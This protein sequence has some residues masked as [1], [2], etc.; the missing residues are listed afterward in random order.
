MAWRGLLLLVALAAG[1]AAAEPAPAPAQTVFSTSRRFVVSGLP[2]VDAATLCA[3]AEDVAERIEA[4]THTPLGFGDAE[5]ILIR[6]MDGAE[7]GESRVVRAQGYV[8]GRL[9]QKL[10]VVRPAAADQ[11]DMIESLCGLIVSRQIAQ[12]QSDAERRRALGH[13]PDWLAVGLAQNLYRDLRARNTRLAVDLHREGVAPSVSELIGLA[14]MPPGRWREKY[15][16]GLAVAWLLSQPDLPSHWQALLQRLAGGAPVG[17]DWIAG[18]FMRFTGTAALEAGWETRLLQQRQVVFDLAPSRE[19]RVERL[20]ELLRVRPEE[21][22]LA[23]PDGKPGLLV[24]GDLVSRRR[25]DWVPRLARA[26]GLR[27]AL[28]GGGQPQE[29]QRIVAQYK[30]FFDALAAEKPRRSERDLRKLLETADAALTTYRLRREQELKYVSDVAIW[31]DLSG[32]ATNGIS[33]PALP[34]RGEVERYLDHMESIQPDAE[35]RL[36]EPPP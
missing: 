22:G 11:E 10:V 36:S 26:V 1:V 20:S 18:E 27:M 15:F 9:Q 8:D 17:P 33:A 32:A 29:F 34:P 7:S 2:S 3:W 5:Y 23:L 19:D 21:Y 6:C 24:P 31:L 14:Q 12:R 25:E 30:A 28:L 4:R 16:C 35:I 13:A